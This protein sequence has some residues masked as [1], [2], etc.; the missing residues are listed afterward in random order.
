MRLIFTNLAAAAALA[1]APVAAAAQESEAAAPLVLSTQSAGPDL[2]FTLG[3]GAK[4]APDYFGSSDYSIG[5]SG[6]FSFGY[7][8]LPGG[9]SFG[10]LDTSPDAS[11][12]G[13]RGSFRFVGER[14]AG[15]HPELTGLNKIDNTLELGLGVAYTSRNFDA[16]ADMR[17]GFFGH[18]ALVGEVG[19]DFKLQPTDRLTLSLGPRVQIGSNKFN[20]TYF[21][22]TAAE[23][24]ASGLAAYNPSGGAVSA[25]IA[26]GA[27][28][29]FNDDWGIEGQVTWDRFT[30]DA[31]DSPIVQQ[32]DRDQYTIS[33]GV[34]RRIVLDF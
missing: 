14:S 2:V 26:L 32:G 19:A 18:E 4:L 8:R 31:A 6:S 34:T 24:A 17:Y 10:N 13:L 21:G 20:D 7:L 27:R 22:V 9:R 3:A 11:S 33:V 12:F 23:S 29:Q 28:Y 5:P 15:D 1:L 25:G 16:F 30:G